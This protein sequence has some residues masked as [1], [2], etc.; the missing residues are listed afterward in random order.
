MDGGEAG[1]KKGKWVREMPW[2]TVDLID[3]TSWDEEV[4]QPISTAH[5]TYSVQD[6]ERRHMHRET[7][8][9]WLKNARLDRER[10]VD[11][12]AE[13]KKTMLANP[14]YGKLYSKF[15][16]RGV[17]THDVEGKAVPGEERDRLREGADMGMVRGLSEPIPPLPQAT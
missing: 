13:A 17:P 7:Y 8:M 5:L 15:D 6:L 1:K 12:K 3:S 4:K 14:Q 10:K 2:Q 11:M 16:A 9:D